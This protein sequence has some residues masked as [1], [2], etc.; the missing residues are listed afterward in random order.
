MNQN[1]MLFFPQRDLDIL[2]FQTKQDIGA[3][4]LI[5]TSQASLKVINGHPWGI[6]DS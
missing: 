3:N 5:R 4:A 2:V 6:C 1:I